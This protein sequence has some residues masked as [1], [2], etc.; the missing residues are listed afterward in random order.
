MPKKSRRSR[1]KYRPASRPASRATGGP[2]ET[3][4]PVVE[5]SK[6]APLPV[7]QAS[8]LR[9]NRYEYLAPE[10]RRIG[11]IGGFLFLILIALTFV[12]G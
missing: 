12:L 9:A 2:V 3:R 6:L 10:L 11:I 1:S 7:S 4:R 5:T 8:A